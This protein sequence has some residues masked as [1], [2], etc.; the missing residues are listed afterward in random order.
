MDGL[1]VVEI[2]DLMKSIYKWEPNKHVKYV[3]LNIFLKFY[4]DIVSLF[5]D[6]GSNMPSFPPPRKKKPFMLTVGSLH[7]LQSLP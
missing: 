2:P 1:N 6:S 3:F 7:N 4:L 5:G